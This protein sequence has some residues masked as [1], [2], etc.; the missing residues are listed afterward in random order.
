MAHTSPPSGFVLRLSLVPS[1]ENSIL[2]F[3]NWKQS[4][5][6][7]SVG[8]F[9]SRACCGTVAPPCRHVEAC[10]QRAVLVLVSFAALDCM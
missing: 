4:L 6:Q 8:T 2:G 9:I 7:T 10:S 1:V 5:E 3:H